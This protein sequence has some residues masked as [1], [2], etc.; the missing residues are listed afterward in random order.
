MKLAPLLFTLAAILL[1]DYVDCAYSQEEVEVGSG[2]GTLPDRLT[3]HQRRRAKGECAQIAYGKKVCGRKR[4][5]RIW[6]PCEEIHGPNWGKGQRDNGPSPTTTRPFSTPRPPIQHKSPTLRVQDNR[7]TTY[8][9]RKSTNPPEES[10]DRTI[11]PVRKLIYFNR[12]YA[13]FYFI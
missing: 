5:C 7:A 8:V 9:P 3:E 2:S 6:K 1:S 11:L 12:L 10:T 13:Y 4:R